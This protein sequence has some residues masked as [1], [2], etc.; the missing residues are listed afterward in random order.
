MAPAP[1]RGTPARQRAS[2]RT[3]AARP[4]LRLGRSAANVALRLE[5]G[6]VIATDLEVHKAK[7]GYEGALLGYL[8]YDRQKK[9]FT[10]FDL[11]ALGENWW[12]EKQEGL[13]KD[14]QA[15]AEVNLGKITVG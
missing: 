5:G 2:G 1:G 11:L 6:A 4:Q 7:H 14:F 3:W 9:V 13:V 15:L 8:N 12:N 10:R